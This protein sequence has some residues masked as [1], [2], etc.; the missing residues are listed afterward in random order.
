MEPSKLEILDSDSFCDS[1]LSD[2]HAKINIRDK[3]KV[4]II[5]GKNCEA[6][7]FFIL[8]STKTFLFIT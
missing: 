1:G 5:G 4:R 6:S 8:S 7:S 3:Q 2:N